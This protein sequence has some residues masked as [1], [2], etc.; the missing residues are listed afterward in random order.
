MVCV[1]VVEVRLRE[2]GWSFEEIRK[3]AANNK[4]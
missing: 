1:L 2:G 3:L 4:T